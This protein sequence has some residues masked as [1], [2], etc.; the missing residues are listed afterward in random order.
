MKNV[1]NEF[2]DVTNLG[3]AAS[4]MNEDGIVLQAER[5]D[6]IENYGDKLGE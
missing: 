2:A 4:R 3:D 1:P 6:G 5:W